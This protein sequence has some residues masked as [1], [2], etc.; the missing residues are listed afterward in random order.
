MQEF[1]LHCFR[2]LWF[3]LLHPEIF[4]LHLFWEKH[5]LAPTGFFALCS[6]IKNK[7]TKTLQNI[8]SFH[9]KKGEKLFPILISSVCLKSV[10]EII[11]TKL[12]KTE[13]TLE[14]A[15]HSESLRETK[16]LYIQ[17][18][19]SKTSKTRQCNWN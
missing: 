18:L 15:R 17:H 5:S 16:R 8:F 3:I 13:N 1:I 12:S 19:Q 2:M 9:Q 4:L 10:T 7:K 6:Y 14:L 11:W